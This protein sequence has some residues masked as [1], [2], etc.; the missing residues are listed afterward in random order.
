MGK[1]KEKL[2]ERF[3]LRVGHALEW[4]DDLGKSRE[5]ITY[6]DGLKTGL[7]D[8][9]EIV[10]DEP[11]QTL[12]YAVADGLHKDVVLACELVD[13]WND[14]PKHEGYMDVEYSF[15]PTTRTKHINVHYYLPDGKETDNGSK[16]YFFDSIEKP[17]NM[18]N[19]VL[20]VNTGNI[21][22]VTIK[23]VE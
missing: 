20:F 19:L 16:C 7:D 14:D 17:E 13:M 8:A 15:Y 21:P 5:C 2:N 22:G 11:D 23:E 9:L 18:A 10:G 4:G 12:A 6:L 1:I 3:S